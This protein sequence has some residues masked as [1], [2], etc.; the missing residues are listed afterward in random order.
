VDLGEESDTL[1]IIGER[2]AKV[3]NCIFHLGVWL[4]E[5]KLSENIRKNQRGKERL[6][7]AVFVYEGKILEKLRRASRLR[8]RKI[9]W[10]GRTGGREDA[11]KG[12]ESMQSK[13]KEDA[14]GTGLRKGRCW[15][16]EGE[17]AE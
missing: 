11:G 8:Q 1:E 12:K 16:R 3:I 2:S 17:Q 10:W 7:G 13:A 6:L 15:E 4:E 9:L 5:G 14:G